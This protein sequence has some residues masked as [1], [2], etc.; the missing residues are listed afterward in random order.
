MLNLR[1]NFNI[2]LYSF[3]QQ[4][5]SKFISFP[6]FKKK[7]SRKNYLFPTQLRCCKVQNRTCSASYYHLSHIFVHGHSIHCPITIKSHGLIVW[8][9]HCKN[10]E[11]SLMTSDQIS[12]LIDS[13]NYFCDIIKFFYILQFYM[14]L[15]V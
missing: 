8:R 11:K 6:G 14:N 5:Y 3:R 9:W 1:E 10:K 4:T 12:R 2:K 15:L 7:D 13:V